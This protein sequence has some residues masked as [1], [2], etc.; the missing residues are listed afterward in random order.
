MKQE[1]IQNPNSVERA[2]IEA[3]IAAGSH[4]ILQF[5]RPIYSSE[6]LKKINN[7]CGELGKNLEVRFYGHKF[8]ASHL[9]FLPDVAALSIDCLLE[10][11]NLSA[12]NDLAN[13]QR[14][15]L[16]IY[17]LDEPNFL[18]SLQLRNLEQFALCETA[19][20]NFDLTPLQVCSKLA[21][22]YL[23]G[24][25]KNI[26]CLANLPSLRILSLGQ[27]PKKQNLE[28]VSKIPNLRRLTIILGGREN[29]LEIQ[30]STLEE[31]E[32]LRVLGFGN[33]E[34]LH[35]FPSLRSLVIE[36]Q[37][38][39]ETINFTVVNQNLK[40]FRIFNCK[41]LRNVEGLHYL[42]NLKS[43][44]I[45]M[46]ALDIESILRQ[47]LPTALK[48]F[49]FYTGKQKENARIREKLNTLGYREYER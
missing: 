13:L 35:A 39:L 48:V 42:A 14:L 33:L 17:R 2:A 47:H 25:T 46:T 28:F 24:H 1:R 9:H 32:I 30:H 16:G 4:I 7:L 6:L 29:I 45:G 38:R 21:E 11:T 31:L 15:S 3:K 27:I 20:S 8:D 49:G 36:D 18:R 43:I 41:T 12:L 44:R 22:F 5:D 26:D 10:A 34:N 37:I 40:S 23:V 19:K